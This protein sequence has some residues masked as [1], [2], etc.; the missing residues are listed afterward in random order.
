MQ[1]AQ[2]DDFQLHSPLGVGTVGTIYA[3]TYLGSPADK[4]GPL[5]IK[6]LH[7]RC[8]A[9]PLIRARFKREIELLQRMR[10]PNIIASFAGGETD[11]KLFYVMERVDGGSVSDLLKHRGSLSWQVVVSIVRQTASALQCAHNHGVVHRDLK[12]SNLFLTL[13]GQVKLGDFGI[14]RDLKNADLSSTGM[15]VGTHAYMAPEQI[16]G[17]RSLSGK[18]DL[19]S[20]GCCAFEMLTGRPPFVGDNYVQLFEQHLRATPPSVA[21]FVPQCPQA[22][23]DIIAQMLAKLPEQ[24]PFNARSVQGAM[25]EI[26]Q[27]LMLSPGDA[28]IAGKLTDDDPGRVQL[29]QC[30]QDRFG[31]TARRDVSWKSLVTVFML[32]VALVAAAAWLNR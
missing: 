24:R 14:A 1:S 21:D 6:V 16:T 2:L 17:D 30:I 26:T 18:A 4:H 19:Y 7:D 9:D 23:Q 11:G 28:A 8:A 27:D 29:A 13:D 31:T 20:L 12:P 15:T 5:A 10:H 22:L 3:A 25:V 32:V